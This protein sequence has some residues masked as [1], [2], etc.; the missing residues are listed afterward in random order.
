MNHTIMRGLVTNKIRV[1]DHTTQEL[2]PIFRDKLSEALSC[3]VLR[4]FPGIT[5]PW[6]V[7]P[8]P[9]GFSER[10]A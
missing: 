3:D 4:V 1:N 9:A 8:S 6:N 7:R 5:G 10:S 2:C